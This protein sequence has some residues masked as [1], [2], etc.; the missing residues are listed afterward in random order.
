MGSKYF[1]GSNDCWL[2]AHLDHFDLPE[3]QRYTLACSRKACENSE[4]LIWEKGA[5]AGKREGEPVIISF[6]T[7]FCPFLSHLD[8]AVRLSKF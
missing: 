3:G 8:I 5:A 6:T 1:T 7:L 2:L 4:Y